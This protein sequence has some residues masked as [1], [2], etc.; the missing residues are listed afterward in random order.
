MRQLDVISGSETFF[1]PEYAPW[2]DHPL[3]LERG[4]Q[5]RFQLLVHALHQYL[6]FTTVLE[7]VAILPVTMRLSRGVAT[8]GVDLSVAMRTDA[9]RI[10]TDEAWHAQFCHE[11][12]LQVGQRTGAVPAAITDPAFATE[13]EGARQSF[14]QAHRALADLAFACV[15]ETLISGFLVSVP[16]DTRLPEP[17][18]QI[19]A[20]HASD[21]G[22]HHAYF[23]SFLKQL[24]P[25]LARDEKTLVGRH[26]PHFVRTF[27]APDPAGANAA[28]RQLQF[29]AAD[30]AAILADV[31]DQW[32]ANSRDA[33]A[34]AAS[35]TV[36]AFAEVGAFDLPEVRDAFRAA[37]LPGA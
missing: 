1:P 28:L 11:F 29:G 17:V 7:Q 35:G 22:R 20:D 6:H 15:S 8:S 2:V 19:V 9:F 36:R 24:W 25:G 13:L 26:A 30:R 31:M 18:R 27:L 3:V 37:G 21:E 16:R 33:H 34:L 5:T 4:P 32:K 10:T 12:M 23:R 14:G